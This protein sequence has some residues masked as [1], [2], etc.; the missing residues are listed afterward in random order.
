MKKL[1]MDVI[2]GFDTL[3]QYEIQIDLVIN[4]VSTRS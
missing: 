4:Q 1:I 2:F 3:Q